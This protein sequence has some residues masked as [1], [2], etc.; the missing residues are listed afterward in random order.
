MKGRR[1]ED[2]LAA[3]QE[4]TER[5]LS[6]PDGT[7]QW[8]HAAALADRLQM[9]RANVARELNLLYQNGQL[10]KIQGKPTYFLSRFHLEQHFPTAFFPSTLPKGCDI[11]GFASAS[12]LPVQSKEDPA[13]VPVLLDTL[14]GARCT[15]RDEILRAKAAV[16]YPSHD[17]H[18]LIYGNIGVGK[19]ELAHRMYLH[20]VAVGSIAEDAPY[21]V[22]NCRE[23]EASPQSFLNQLFGYSKDVSL[24]GGKS[25]RGLIERAAGGLLCLNGVE[26]LPP[27]V[28][29]SLMTLIDKKTFTRIGEPSVTRYATVMIVAISTDPPDAPSI[30]L[31]QQHFPVLIHVPDLEKW[32]LHELAE[33]VITRFQE[34]STTTGLCFRL[35]AD[36]LAAFLRASYADNLGSLYRAIRTTCALV[37]MRHSSMLPH[38]KI[39]EITLGSF[40]PDFLEGIRPDAR[41]DHEISALLTELEL[42][43]IT[44]TPKGF[45]TNRYS[46]S[47]FMDRLHQYGTVTAAKAPPEQESVTIL[48]LLHG[49]T[50]AEQMADYVNAAVGQPCV[51]GIS[52][53]VNASLAS[54]RT[55]ILDALQQR[56]CSAGV[57][58]LAD[59]E[60]LTGL[61]ELLF[62]NT[63]IHSATVANV[64][65]PVL[66]A[67]AEASRQ[68]EITLHLLAE[69]ARS[70]VSAAPLERGSDFLDNTIKKMLIPTLTFLNPQKACSVLGST[71]T[72][73]LIDFGIAP[74]NDITVKFIF[75]CAHML[76]RLIRSEPLKFDGLKAFINANSAFFAKL[77][78][79]M[80]YPAELFGV[81]I[82]ASELAYVA[83]ILLP[84][85]DS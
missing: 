61:N 1:K 65:L 68:P 69:E 84:Y 72:A 28:Q 34:E 4:D 2:V 71:L 24:K 13:D 52:Y 76:E 32:D 17:L 22:V 54:L 64:S 45:S 3:V 67:V 29:H 7:A 55:T 82:P 20:A 83:E 23:Y 14:I 30:S 66:L 36:A 63:G 51:T 19:G 41:A 42:E 81:S 75:H 48:A 53:G 60:P 58:I 59:M 46:E 16:M 9:D 8:S 74:A 70:L 18:T 6:S 56:D 25:R 40:R 43:Y 73:L 62:R 27:A 10:I 85:F 78:K 57:L 37:Y 77:E 47:M 39:I 44:F 15:L 79:H 12:A 50:V 5:M 33:V 26:K 35:R 80:Q 49:E 21:I 31:L 38:S 11:Q